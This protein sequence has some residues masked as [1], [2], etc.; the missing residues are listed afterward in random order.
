MYIRKNI[1][2]LLFV[3]VCFKFVLMAFIPLVS[4]YSLLFHLNVFF[5]YINVNIYRLVSLILTYIVIIL[6]YLYTVIFLYVPL[7]M[8]VLTDFHG[9]CYG[10]QRRNTSLYTYGLFLLGHIPRI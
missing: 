6:L 10:K 9:F 4:L 8:G 2:Y 1:C 3:F 7:L 5:T